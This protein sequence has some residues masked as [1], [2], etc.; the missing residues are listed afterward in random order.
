MLTVLITDEMAFL[1]NLQQDA[2][3]N[4]KLMEFKPPK[5]LTKEKY[6]EIIT[7]IGI[8]N[9]FVIRYPYVIETDKVK[10]YINVTNKPEEIF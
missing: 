10:I 2:N 9:L 8:E 1:G 3:D 4:K 5:N 6:G 7:N